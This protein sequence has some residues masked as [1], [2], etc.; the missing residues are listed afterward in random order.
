MKFVAGNAMHLD[1]SMTTCSYDNSTCYKTKSVARV[2]S[3]SAAS[4]YTSGGQ[5]ITIKG[6]GFD[7]T[8]TTVMIDGAA[9]TIKTITS[10]TITC[11]T[12]SVA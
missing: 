12:G 1:F 6:F 4:G 3:V 9:C 5:T 2:N 8:T 11:E 10:T 7:T